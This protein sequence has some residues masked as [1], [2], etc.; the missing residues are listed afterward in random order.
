M[1]A[2]GS[3]RTSSVRSSPLRSTDRFRR[4]TGKARDPG[5]G[6]RKR[7]PQALDVAWVVLIV[8]AV[9]SFAIEPD[10]ELLPEY[11]FGVVVSLVYLLRVGEPFPPAWMLALATLL[12]AA[13]ALIH[14]LPG[15]D[16]VLDFSEAVILSGLFVAM[17]RQ[18]RRRERARNTLER[19]LYDLSHE[20]RTPVTIA[21][22][23]L[24]ALRRVDVRSSAEIA[25]ALDE[26]MRIEHVIERVLLLAKVEQPGF[27]AETDVDIEPFL[28]EVFLRWTEVAPR[29]WRLGDVPA[30]VLRADPDRLRTAVDALLENAVKY[31]DAE[32]MIELR[33]STRDGGLA[34]EVANEG[35]SLSAVDEQRIFE[36]FSRGDSAGR[37]AT[38]GT[39]LG[40]AIVD[41][42]AKAHGGSCTVASSTATTV[43][44]LRMPTFQVAATQPG[45]LMATP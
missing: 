12:I 5:N 7:R 35:P 33:A 38:E 42:I 20:L 8:A 3:L 18:V 37:Q 2:I 25:I 6:H 43:F 26:L 16:L 27:L 14:L 29:A 41:A 9:A 1:P 34:I 39:G 22:G 30:G 28:E 17:L 15:A 45:D 23:N 40:L 11:L 21:R 31:T 4:I 44:S 36:R 19:L 13:T 32:D 24:D 10:K